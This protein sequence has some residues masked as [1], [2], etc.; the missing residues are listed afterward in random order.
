MY[1]S[2]AGDMT[3]ENT[4]KKQ[5]IHV[6]HEKGVILTKN[7]LARRNWNGSKVCCLCNKLETIQHLFFDCHYARFLWRAVHWEFGIAPPTCVSHLFGGWS[8][9]GHRKHNLL[10]L[11]GTS[12]LCWAI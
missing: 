10:V 4:L 1:E 3:N 12:A 9:L 7:N 5:N 8:K 6:V 2:H 11:S